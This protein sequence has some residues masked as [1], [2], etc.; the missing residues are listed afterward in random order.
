MTFEGA[1]WIGL[2]CFLIIFLFV[3]TMFYAFTL[4]NWIDP[5]SC[6]E[7][8]GQYGVLP[9][10]IG[11]ILNNCNGPCEFRV[12][13][14]AEAAI[15]CDSDSKCDAFYYDSGNMKYVE[16]NSPLTT[17]NPGGTYVRQRKIIRNGEAG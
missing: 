10:V 9:G 14:L 15:R 16:I 2:I 13:S 3:I 6:P 11:T 17:A 12:S 1:G 4:N 5:R 7:S 8:I